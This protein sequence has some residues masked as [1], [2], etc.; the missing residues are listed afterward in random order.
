[1][2]EH[3]FIQYGK[4]NPYRQVTREEWIKAERTAGFYPKFGSGPATGGFSGHGVSGVAVYG[5]LNEEAAVK[6]DGIPGV[7]AAIRATFAQPLPAPEAPVAA[8]TDPDIEALRSTLA[9]MVRSLRTWR[10]DFSTDEEVLLWYELPEHL[11]E[12]VLHG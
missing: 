9:D 2:T 5:D 3:Y 7:A 6:W 1:M 11:V 4:S 10:D 12:W 8:V